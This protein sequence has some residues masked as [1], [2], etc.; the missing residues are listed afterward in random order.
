MLSKMQLKFEKC[1]DSFDIYSHWEHGKT[2]RKSLV[3][4]GNLFLSSLSMSI[5]WG[6]V[7]L[8]FD[9]PACEDRVI[10]TPSSHHGTRKRNLIV[11]LLQCC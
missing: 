2:T 6:G 8:P 9:S 4:D 1:L 10:F 5:W 7:S 11:L 3:S